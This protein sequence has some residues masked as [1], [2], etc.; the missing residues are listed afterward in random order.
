VLAA[1]S[2]RPEWAADPREATSNE[3]QLFTGLEFKKP[4][5]EEDS[6][7]D[8]E[9][10]AADD[11]D[12]EV[13]EAVRDIVREPEWVD[14]SLR[15]SGSHPLTQGVGT[16]V[17]KS[18]KPAQM[19]PLLLPSDDFA[20]ALAVGEASTEA[21]PSGALFVRAH[22][23]GR[24]VVSTTASLFSNRALDKG[25]NAR[26]L[27]NLVEYSVASDGAVL[28]DDLRHGL[29]ASYD[30]A[31]FWRDARVYWTGAVLLMLWF[32]WV[33]GG[34][35]LKPP[36][37]DEAAPDEAA[38][39]VAT[40]DLL[41]RSA[42]PYEAARYLIQGLFATLPKAHSNPADPGSWGWL[43]QQPSVRSSDVADLQRLFK[44]ATEGRSV[45]LLAV[46]R[47]SSAIRRQLAGT[48]NT[49]GTMA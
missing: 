24:I 40:G 1:L 44:D 23:A 9:A 47:I 37:R 39:V 34:T 48:N 20:I 11:E 29:S 12:P 42:K 36:A 28:F 38:L 27:A 49:M 3:I 13:A 31:R 10:D 26:L 18:E 43:E 6:P 16:L 30:P 5:S 4:R 22:G 32:V 25:D 2:D 35:A 45:N 21:A 17:A 19:W 14:I 33:L 41:A 7:E 8:G 15:A 46:H